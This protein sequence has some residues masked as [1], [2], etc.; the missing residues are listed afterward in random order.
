MRQ[1]DTRTNKSKT[2]VKGVPAASACSTAHLDGEGVVSLE[3]LRQRRAPRRLLHLHRR[4]QEG[5]AR[6]RPVAVPQ[7]PF[8]LRRRAIFV[9]VALALALAVFFAVH[10]GERDLGGHVELL[11]LRA[12]Q[13]R[14]PERRRLARQRGLGRG[15]VGAG[16]RR[17]TG[18]GC[19]G[20]VEVVVAVGGRQVP[21]AAGAPGPTRSAVAIRAGS[22]PSVVGEY[23]GRRLEGLHHRRR[24]RVGLVA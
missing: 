10:L 23:V 18:G 24:A 21:L 16:G 11:R 1:T 3:T 2:R 19:G 15:T 22:V 5:V 20:G 4:R 8:P 7:Q 6:R 9:A 12:E 14:L 13:K 17:S